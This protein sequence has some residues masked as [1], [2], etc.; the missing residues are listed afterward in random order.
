MSLLAN[1][2]LIVGAF[3]LL[4]VAVLVWII[5]GWRAD[6]R[7]LD[8]ALAETAE[9]RALLEATVEQYES[10]QAK[11][12]E[13]QSKLDDME[14]KKEVRYVKVKEII[15]RPVYRDCAI[16]DDGVLVNNEAISETKSAIRNT[17]S[18]R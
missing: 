14:Q 11:S 9:I 2:K 17:S 6:S 16:D 7:A 1:W 12:V 18:M 10:A 3:G 4:A 15:D 8:S 5:L 13:I